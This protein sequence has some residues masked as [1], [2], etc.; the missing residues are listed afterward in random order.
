MIFNLNTFIF[1][2]FILVEISQIYYIFIIFKKFQ[3][4]RNTLTNELDRIE[5]KLVFQ[6]D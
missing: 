3:L 1:L 5:S 4:Y 6:K 2:L